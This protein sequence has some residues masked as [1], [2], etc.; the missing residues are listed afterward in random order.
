MFSD[1]F[2]QVPVK[3]PRFPEEEGIIAMPPGSV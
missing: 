1:E 2:Q 3:R